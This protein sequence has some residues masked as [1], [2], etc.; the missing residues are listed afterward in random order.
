MIIEML[1]DMF[2]W[3]ILSI[4]FLVA[5]AV[6]FY[7][8]S[9]TTCHLDAVDCLDFND[10]KLGPLLVPV[11]AMYGEL[12]AIEQL[13]Q[14]SPFFGQTMLWLYVLVSNV[15]L[16]NLLIAMMSDS[17]SEIK[18]NADVEWKFNR[19]NTVIEAVERIH[20]LPPPL[21]LPLLLHK[22]MW[23][24]TKRVMYAPM[25]G[26]AA[27]MPKAASKALCA[28]CFGDESDSDEED[29]WEP[30]GREWLQKRMREEIAKEALLE[31]RKK[32]ENEE[33][34][35]NP[36]RLRRVEVLLEELLVMSEKTE[37][38]VNFLREYMED[39]SADFKRQLEGRRS[40]SSQKGQP[41]S[42]LDRNR[43][44]TD[45]AGAKPPSR[46]PGRAA[47]RRA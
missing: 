2:L 39:Q 25:A 1:Q 23:Y 5:F 22:F 33:E 14:W 28:P 18:E 46:K 43:P 12:G 41:I 30:G 27:C 45:E 11:W 3:I 44:P 38:E 6:T 24:H 7:S 37:R 42:A 17:Y 40:A 16:V 35:S 32:S 15:L 26:C 19:M 8:I 10:A 9:D 31:H 21:S 34:D 47:T 36:E 20:P 29:I 13:D 4:V